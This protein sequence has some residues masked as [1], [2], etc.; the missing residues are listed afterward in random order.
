MQELTEISESLIQKAMTSENVGPSE[1]IAHDV[2]PWDSTAAYGD[3]YRSTEHEGTIGLDY[4]VLRR[5]SNVPVVSA[6]IQTRVNQV[7][8][9]CTPQKDKYSAGFV[10]SPRDSDAEMTDELRDK[11]N[12]LTRWLESCGEGYKYGGADSFE[13][14]IRMIRE[15]R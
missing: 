2:N 11:I 6:I 4:E 9:F 15:T 3:S 12:E 14:F 5:M 7:A 1:P 8:E 13:A 10:I